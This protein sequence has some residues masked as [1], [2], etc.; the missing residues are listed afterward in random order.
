MTAQRLEQAYRVR[1]D[2]AG[3]DGHLRASGFL[4]W[5]QDIAWQHSSAAGFD[6]GWYAARRL[7]WLI[8]AIELNIV[9]AVPYGSG[10]EVSTEVI[11]F[12]RVWARRRS[13]FRSAD[14][15]RTC[16]TA[17]ID[18][19]L[20]SDRGRPVRVP[21]EIEAVFPSPPARFTPLRVELP[22]PPADASARRFEVRASE[23]DPMGHVNNAAYLDFVDEQLASAGRRADSRRVPRRYRG[24]FLLPAEQGRALVGHGWPDGAGWCYLLSDSEGRVL[25]RGRLEVDLA[26]WVGG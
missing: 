18:W 26:E 19:V 8:R 1:F 13:E 23:V 2:E 17:L 15:G 24:E 9:E 3:A 22:P 14:G 4:R 12:R 20:L 5:A 6:R 10:V 21:T 11:G 16:A 25:F 7:T